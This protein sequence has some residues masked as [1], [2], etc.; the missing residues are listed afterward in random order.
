MENNHIVESIKR[1]NISTCIIHFALLDLL[2][3]HAVHTWISGF[4]LLDP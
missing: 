4:A 3:E 2:A 1:N